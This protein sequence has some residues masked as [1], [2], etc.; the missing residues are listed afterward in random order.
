MLEHLNL[1]QML[2]PTMFIIHLLHQALMDYGSLVIGSKKMK[3]VDGDDLSQRSFKTRLKF[4]ETNRFLR[5]RI[6]DMVRDQSWEQT[7]LVDHCVTFYGKDKEKVRYNLN[8]LI[9][10][11]LLARQKSIILLP[12]E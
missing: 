9:Q 12:E 4:S 7:D 8:N 5:G 6:M 11:G 3:S 2:K 1:D 10:E